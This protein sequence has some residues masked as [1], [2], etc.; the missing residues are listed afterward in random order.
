[1]QES[2]SLAFSFP[3]LFFFIPQCLLQKAFCL[4]EPTGAFL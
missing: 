1:M 4:G 3:V 2:G